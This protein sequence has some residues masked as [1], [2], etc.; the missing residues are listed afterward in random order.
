MESRFASSPYRMLAEVLRQHVDER[1]H[2]RRDVL[3][4]SDDS[5]YCIKVARGWRDPALPISKPGQSK[6]VRSSDAIMPA[7]SKK[8]SNAARHVR[9]D[10]RVQ[11]LELLSV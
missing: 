6:C 5:S 4:A 2:L 7:R 9:P 11:D 10:L 1:P 8:E 3:P